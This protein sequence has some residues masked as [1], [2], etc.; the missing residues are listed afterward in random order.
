[1]LRANPFQREIVDRAVL[2]PEKMRE[3][4]PF[5]LAAFHLGLYQL[6]Q[7]RIVAVI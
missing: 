2:S 3:S 6:D 7:R 5:D 4:L 1:M